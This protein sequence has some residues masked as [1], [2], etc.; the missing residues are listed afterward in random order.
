METTS[1]GGPPLLHRP[2]NGPGQL[3]GPS[4]FPETQGGLEV[5][6][7][8]VAEVPEAAQIC[9]RLGPPAPVE[10]QMDLPVRVRG[11]SRPWWL[12]RKQRAHPS[13]AERFPEL[14]GMEP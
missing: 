4:R 8:R 1:T 6:V 13:T 11:G 5:V 9:R 10:G 2:P 14:R 7:R 3:Q 12:S